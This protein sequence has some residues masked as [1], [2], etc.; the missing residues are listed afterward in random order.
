MREITKRGFSD[1]LKFFGW[2]KRSI[3]WPALVL[4]GAVLHYVVTGSFTG[5][6]EELMLWVTYTLAPAGAFALI[7]L[8]YNLICAPY[9]I[10][11]DEH[12]ET[13]RLTDAASHSDSLTN[14]YEHRD[15]FTLK[16]AAALL[17]NS[18]ITRSEV[19]GVA[20][21]YLSELEEAAYSGRL[22]PVR[23]IS[24]MDRAAYRL[25]KLQIGHA[26][27][28][29][30]EGLKIRKSELERYADKNGL[31]LPKPPFANSL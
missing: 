31:Q 20:A 6:K 1:T 13:K 2:E 3:I 10:E 4:A 11:K 28:P 25:S 22:T 14:F 23:G 8:A 29:S 16:E 26:D 15:S 18:P 27:V 5:P 21:G 12:N 17:A 19:I 7:L 9:R 24:D 30:Q